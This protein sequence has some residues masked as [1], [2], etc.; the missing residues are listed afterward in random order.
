MDKPEA[1]LRIPKGVLK[2]SGHNP[3]SRAAQNYSVVED[4]GHTPC[5]MFALEVLQSCPS[6]RKA[7]ISALGVNDDDSSSVIK[8]KTAG[9]LYT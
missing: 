9:L 7:L 1:P 3:N 5:A 8:F 2:C 4:W 6:Q